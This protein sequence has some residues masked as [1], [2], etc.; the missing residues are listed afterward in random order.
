MELMYFETVADSGFAGDIHQ[1]LILADREFIP[2]LSCRGSSTQADLSASESVSQGAAAYYE[3][4]STQP[5]VLAVED[6]RCLGFMAFKFDYTCQQITDRCLP[7][8]YASTCVVH[9]DTRGRGLMGQFYEKMMAL[10]PTHSIYTRTWHTNYSHLKVLDRLG[11]R[12][13]ARLKDH[14]GPGLDTVYFAYNPQ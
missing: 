4:M 12:E 3:T 7:N 10:F 14:R 11:F 8:L 9:P 2:P 6:G 5:A 1:L 13:H